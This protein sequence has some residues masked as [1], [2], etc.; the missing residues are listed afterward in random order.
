MGQ[1]HEKIK[2]KG[3][4]LKEERKKGRKRKTNRTQKARHLVKNPRVQRHDAHTKSEAPS[5]DAPNCCASTTHTPPKRGVI[6]GELFW[7]VVAGPFSARDPSSGG[8][9]MFSDSCLLGPH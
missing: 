2:K 9:C 4:R 7:G 5:F 6:K 1:P 3:S 8:Q